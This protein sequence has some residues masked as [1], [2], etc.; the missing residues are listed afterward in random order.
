VPVARRALAQVVDRVIYDP[1]AGIEISY[2]ESID[3]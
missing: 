1:V 2:R 3:V